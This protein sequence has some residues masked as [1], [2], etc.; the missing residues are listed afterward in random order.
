MAERPCELG[1]FKGWVTL[2]LNFRLKGYVLHQYLWKGASPTNHCW[3]QRTGVIAIS[4]GIKISTVHFL[5]LSQSM[6]VTDGHTN[7]R[8][9]IRMDR[10]T[11]RITAA[12]TKLAYLLAR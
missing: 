3:C 5:V 10:Q 9:D 2:K 6:P 8:M 11:D 1:D 4:C 7:G 12:N